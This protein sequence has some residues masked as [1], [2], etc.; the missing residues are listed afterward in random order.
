METLGEATD[1]LLCVEDPASELMMVETLMENV[2]QHGE[3]YEVS[4][5]YR[6]LVPLVQAFTHNFTGWIKFVRALRDDIADGSGRSSA[7][8]VQ[9][10]R[11]FRTLE[12]RYAQQA[13]RERIRQAVAWLESHYPALT[14]DQK[15]LWV[16][17]LEQLW[18]KQR[19]AWLNG[20]RQG[21]K[22]L[23][24]EDQRRVLDEFWADVDENIRQGNLPK[25]E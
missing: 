15:K 16:K 9:M 25:Y 10:Q 19:H 23:T 20:H 12:V 2:R 3:A 7:R 22:H 18:M 14:A 1:F 24:L 8:Y 4:H 17:R 13:R 6:H 21:N 5:T 11:F